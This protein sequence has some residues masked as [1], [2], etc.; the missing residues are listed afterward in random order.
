[1]SS[2][3]VRIALGAAL[4]A[5]APL[6]P[7][8]TITT[9]SVAAATVITTAL[10]HGLT[11]GTLVTI[12][13]HTGST[14]AI[15]GTYQITVTSTTKFTIPLAVTIAG[16]GGTVT[17]N[18]TAR[19]NTTFSPITG[20]PWQSSQVVFAAPDNPVYGATYF[21]QGFYQV[22]LAYPLNTGIGA[23]ATRAELV[24]S[25]FKRGNTYTY[26]GTTVNITR[27]PEILAGY[28]T[29][30]DFVIPVRIRFNAQVQ[31]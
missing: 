6:I 21:S 24:A 15:S 19:E 8:A 25:T 20:V 28:P 23:A 13:G 27:T 3:N 17:A 31:A 26:G 30:S 29:S 18:L 1:M 16:S 12:A 9:S 2:M 11:T 7:A 10:A 5:M 4:D 22:N 14:P